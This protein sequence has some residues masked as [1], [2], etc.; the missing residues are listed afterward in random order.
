M[1]TY[2]KNKI[3]EVKFN[4]L[5]IGSTEEDQSKKTAKEKMLD[6]SKQFG[7]DT[8]CK[9]SNIKKTVSKKKNVEKKKILQSVLNLGQKNAVHICK[10]CLME[11]NSTLPD[12]IALHKRY[13]L[14]VLNALSWNV[15]LLSL[16]SGSVLNHHALL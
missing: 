5:L 6:F 4:H 10:E 8:K 1:L 12:D 16:K 15:R 11:Y 14:S 9:K 3:K 13:H 7:I 2:S